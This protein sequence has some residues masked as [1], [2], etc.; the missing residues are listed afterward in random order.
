MKNEPRE[1]ETL[2][3][4]CRRAV[5]R[6]SWSAGG[7]EPVEGWLALPTRMVESDLEQRRVIVTS[8]YLVIDCPQY[9]PDK[10]EKA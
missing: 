2:C 4:R 7:F 9:L 3:W 8:S 5:G 6:C 1:A 10:E